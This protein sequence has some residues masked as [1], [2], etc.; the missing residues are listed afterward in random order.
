MKDFFSIVPLF[1]EN[2]LPGYASP[3]QCILGLLC[4]CMVPKL[5]QSLHQKRK[6]GSC[7]QGSYCRKSCRWCIPCCSSAIGCKEEQNRYAVE[8]KICWRVAITHLKTRLLFKRGNLV[9]EAKRREDLYKE[10]GNSQEL[11]LHGVLLKP[12]IVNQGHSESDN[13]K[14]D[15]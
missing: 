10:G 9:H 7:C 2:C 3:L 1:F 4:C 8:C 14:A 6:K 5:D 11:K 12:A 13:L 15:R